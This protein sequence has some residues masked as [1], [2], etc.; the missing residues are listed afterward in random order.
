MSYSRW[1]D[2]VWYTYA[3]VGGGFTISGEGNFTD[4]ECKEWVGI[5]T[6]LENKRFERR[7][8]EGDRYTEEELMELKG[9]VDEYLKDEDVDTLPKEAE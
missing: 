5:K 7:P 4:E 2:S 6:K 9:Y 8:G 1:I 3:D